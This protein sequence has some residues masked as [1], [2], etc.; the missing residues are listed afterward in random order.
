MTIID[1]V[2]TIIGVLTF[3]F[4]FSLLEHTTNK[5][6]NLLL[7]KQQYEVCWYTTNIFLF[8]TVLTVL[9]MTILLQFLI[10]LM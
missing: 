1:L 6:S 10:L 7:A 9:L 4:M 8:S 5:Y 3:T 2:L